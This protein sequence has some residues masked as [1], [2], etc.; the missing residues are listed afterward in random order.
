MGIRR[1]FSTT[2]TRRT[3]FLVFVVVVGALVVSVF[4]QLFSSFLRTRVFL[5]F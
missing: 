1:F 3:F 2:V 4:A 5:L